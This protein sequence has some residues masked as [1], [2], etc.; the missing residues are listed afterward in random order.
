MYPETQIGVL[1][2]KDIK[3][4]YTD[5]GLID[6]LL[7]QE[8][9]KVISELKDREM[10]SYEYVK[11]WRETYSKFGSKPSK[12]NSSIESLLKT[13]LSDKTGNQ[14]RRINPLVDIYNLISI[15][16]RIPAGGDDIE[17]ISGNIQ[18]T[19]ADG[20]EKFRKLNSDEYEIADE[21]E[22]IYRDEEEVLCRRWNWRE[23]DKSKLTEKTEKVCLFV[24]GVQLFPK[25]VINEI[26]DELAELIEKFCGG[27]VI[28]K[29]VL[30]SDNQSV[31]I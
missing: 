22:V 25:N 1:I 21:N 14:I 24:E 4:N 28:C 6:N 9:I 13:I 31:E 26:I 3:N 7:K 10:A 19:F 17:K 30:N 12:Y 2:M 23:C 29:E 20:N 5:G 15:K 18:L 27:S 8:E 11:I 16:H